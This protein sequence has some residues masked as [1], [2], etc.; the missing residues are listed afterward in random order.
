[1]GWPGWWRGDYSPISQQGG[2]TAF[3]YFVFLILD[4]FRI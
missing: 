2:D 4:L 1:M 3:W